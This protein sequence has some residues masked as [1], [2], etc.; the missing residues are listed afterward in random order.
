MSKR[1][2]LVPKNVTK[3]NVPCAFGGQVSEVQIYIGSPEAK[4]NPIYFQAKFIQDVK[5]GVIPQSVLDSLEKLQKLSAENGVPFEELCRYAL[6]SI[7]ET[8]GQKQI[9][10]DTQL[11][12]SVEAN[13]DS[14]DN[15]TLEA[16]LA[17][18]TESDTD[19]SQ[20][21]ESSSNDNKNIN[22]VEEKK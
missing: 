18:Q 2:K 12:E 16:T 9:N 10:S 15:I 14:D 22:T 19:L 7:A 20:S 8:G 21:E 13:N 6:N 11:P 4:H 5:G 1:K 17:K 3:F